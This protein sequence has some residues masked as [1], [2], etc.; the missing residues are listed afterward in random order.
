[1]NKLTLLSVLVSLMLY[2]CG[3]RQVT[4]DALKPNLVLPIG[5]TLVI[6]TARFSP[7][8]QYVVTSSTDG[9]AKLWD[10]GSGR[11]LK[12]FIGHS[13]AVVSAEFS[14]D[15]KKIVTAS[16]DNSVKIWDIETGESLI[17]IPNT[18]SC[19]SFSPDGKRVVTASARAAQ[20]WDATNGELVFNLESHVQH[21]TSAKFNST[22][23][24]F[25]T[26]S[27]DGTAKVWDS[28]NGNL[29]S[30]L[31]ADSTRNEMDESPEIVAEFDPSEE[32]LVIT[33]SVNGSKLWELRSGKC[34]AKMD[35][36][37]ARFSRDGKSILSYKSDTI[38][39]KSK[40]NGTL[41]STFFAPGQAEMLALS[42]D[43]ERI[44]DVSEEG[45]RLWNSNTK[46]WEYV[47][48]HDYEWNET[49]AFLFS[50]EFSSDNK[51][52]ITKSLFNAKIWDVER[53]KLLAEFTPHVPYIGSI[54][55][56]VDG[57]LILT[58]SSLWDSNNGKL[59]QAFKGYQSKLSPTG[60]SLVSSDFDSIRMFNIETGRQLFS[61]EGNP[62]SSSTG[63]IRFSKDG[64]KF[65][66]QWY[67]N[68]KVWSSLDGKLLASIPSL[69]N[70][71]IIA[72]FSPDGKR[73]ITSERDNTAKIW[74]SSTGKME[75][76][77]VGHSAFILNAEFSP[78]SKIL[79]TAAHDSIIKIWN[80]GS[81][82]TIRDLKGHISSVKSAKFSGNGKMI[83]SASMDSTVRIWDVESGRCVK[84]L[85][86]SSS[87]TWAQFINNDNGVLSYSDDN[88]VSIWDLATGKI[89]VDMN[90]EVIA[91]DFSDSSNILLTASSTDSNC[92]LWDA[93]TGKELL[94]W[95]SVDSS[96]WVVTHPS[97]LFD[98]SQGAMDKLYFVQG[99]DIIDFAQLK[100]RY[101]EP[102]LW[103]KVMSG[104]KLREV[105]AFKSIELPPDIEQ[106]KEDDFGVANLTFKNREGGIGQISVT[107][108]GLEVMEDIRPS[109][110][111]PKK[112]SWEYELKL[113]S[114][115]NLKKGEDN[116][117]EVRAWN[118]GH[119]VISRP[120][121]IKFTPAST[122]G[123]TAEV[124][125]TKEKKPIPNIHI[126]TCGVS[127][128]T[129]N[130]IDLKYATKDAESMAKALQLGAN[131]LVGTGKTF[132][133]SL[134]D[135][136]TLKPTKANIQK[137]F[138]EISKKSSPNDVF[139]VY[140]SGHGI[141]W[142]GDNGDFYYLTS[143]AYSTE[144]QAY[145]DPAIRTNATIS[146]KEL[147]ELFKTV[148]SDKRVLMIDAC[149][150]GK[151]VQNLVASR[152]I[153]SSTLRAL[154]RLRDRTGFHI[155]TG[156]AA[157]AVS[158]EAS[159][160]GQGVLTYSLIEGI[161]GASLKENKF[162]DINL[163][164]QH[165]KERVPELAKGIG[166]IQSPQVF[167]PQ[168]AQSFDIG[169]LDD[170]IK[171]QIPLPKTRPVFVRSNFMNEQALDDTDDLGT[172][173]DEA[174]NELSAKGE[175]API[176][177]MDIQKYD[178]GCKISGKYKKANGLITATYKI[179]CEGKEQI[180]T[181]TGKTAKEVAEKIVG[182]IDEK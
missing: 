59:I 24:L 167:S 65:L 90:V 18:N 9:T 116:L 3:E 110:F 108:N 117:I 37:F 84:T 25:L 46:T 120:L 162:V 78:D 135:N 15:G 106:A 115:P 118:E 64:S 88:K 1:M 55:A 8:N 58:N 76:N 33:R 133:Y 138:Q 129:G 145:N 50:A 114:L 69:N 182:E 36:E 109:G 147:I 92:R 139:V 11:L 82:K 27:S 168:G 158:Y 141:N 103:K 96:D 131:K 2:S 104:E 48:P 39:V 95:I 80:T 47:F 164:F 159:R 111:N 170:E 154:D 137:T 161:K 91:S 40:N 14:P 142:G 10:A 20:V 119:W 54:E 105:A 107:L 180:K 153:S 178:E 77:L 21:I 125:D 102:G 149:A 173:L 74:N 165:A 86:H 60:K 44:V 99:L 89:S 22:G 43:G 29:L 130:A 38:R 17:T 83:V 63:E 156:C 174:L 93:T 70:D 73:V 6:W 157:D 71:F 169:E 151:M 166:G 68:V 7:N 52:I 34:L 172:Q 62:T 126:L 67:E 175:K 4:N 163:L 94:S 66:V 45:F 85:T 132:V 31:M 181:V 79:I 121:Q 19:A 5:H 128:Y 28:R 123:A 127:D 81:G 98:A 49:D 23:N 75:H 56:S 171:K 61:V 179:K 53:G 26:T 97:G 113:S 12:S 134:T 32:N 13:A 152:D 30:T 101:Y 72:E 148:P 177:F 150:S 122:R 100:E 136:S 16:A 143:D 176:L 112:K 160:F 124:E 51:R 42:P 87:V 41:E 146:S 57:K 140:L 144:L 155:F 35:D